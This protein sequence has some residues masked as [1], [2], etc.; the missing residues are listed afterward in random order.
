MDENQVGAVRETAG[1]EGT[2]VAQHAMQAAGEVRST[3]REQVGQV[4]HEATGQAKHVVHDMR[5]RVASE[6][7]EQARKVSRQIDRIADE[8][9][10]M[11]DGSGPDSL[12]AGALRQVSDAGRQAARYLDERGARG[13]LDSA[14]DFARRKPG[15]FLIGAAVAGFLVA[16]A[17]KSMSGSD[18]PR[19]A[20]PQRGYTDQT[21]TTPVTTPSA[22]P[23]PSPTPM[24]QPAYGTVAPQAPSQHPTPSP[25][26]PYQ[27]EGAPYVQR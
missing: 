14:Q 8:L 6:A 21:P 3:A 20:Q 1:Q 4:A 19:Q 25:R 7:E 26:T 5:E 10:T 17:A 24:A 22:V 9:G 18:Q 12:T 13:L 15:T 23:T 27:S 11:A 16:R 2:A